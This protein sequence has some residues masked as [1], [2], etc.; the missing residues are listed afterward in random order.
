MTKLKECY[1]CGKKY[2]RLVGPHI[3]SHGIEIINGI[4]YHNG[5]N[6]VFW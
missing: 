2:K 6:E 4:V 3:K 1:M 5:V